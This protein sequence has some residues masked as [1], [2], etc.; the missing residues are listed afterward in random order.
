MLSN[1]NLHQNT[2]PFIG[3]LKQNMFTYKQ[4]EEFFKISKGNP[5]QAYPQLTH[6]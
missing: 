6:L 4:N 2:S 3:I 5:Q 1:K